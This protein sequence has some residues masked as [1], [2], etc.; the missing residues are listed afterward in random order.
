[1]D[2]EP[3]FKEVA[4]TGTGCCLLIPAA[5]VLPSTAVEPIG[6]TAAKLGVVTLKLEEAAANIPPEE[7]D[8]S[9]LSNINWG[10][11]YD[12]ARAVLATAFFALAEVFPSVFPQAFPHL[13]EFSKNVPEGAVVAAAFAAVVYGLSF[14]NM[15]EKEKAQK[16]KMESSSKN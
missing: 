7:I 2:K 1:M 15:K 9:E 4:I 6:K 5:I 3:G 13:V 16:A 11:K 8:K 10:K 14:L 12:A